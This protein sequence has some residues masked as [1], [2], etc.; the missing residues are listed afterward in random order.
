MNISF[1][2]PWGIRKI[3]LYFFPTTAQLLPRAAL[4][5]SHERLGE[6]C[7]A[8]LPW[9]FLGIRRHFCTSLGSSHFDLLQPPPTQENQMGFLQA[10]TCLPEE[11]E[12]GK[13]W[14]FQSDPKPAELCAFDVGWAV[15]IQSWSVQC[16][17]KLCLVRKTGIAF[18]CQH[19]MSTNLLLI[20]TTETK[21]KKK[22]M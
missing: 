18:Y 13:T 21:I 11:N 4:T 12:D 9:G 20:V 1:S 14:T 5:S 16:Q 3:Q 15:K 19:S 2:D 10:R 17:W 22:I 6:L 7:W 8:V